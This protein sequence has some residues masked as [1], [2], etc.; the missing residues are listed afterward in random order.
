MGGFPLQLLNSL[1]FWFKFSST[2]VILIWHK[3]LIMLFFVVGHNRHAPSGIPWVL[4]LIILR[5]GAFATYSSD[6]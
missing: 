3:L 1:V 6:F 2:L 5:E 4:P